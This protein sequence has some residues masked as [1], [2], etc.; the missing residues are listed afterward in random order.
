MLPFGG[1]DTELLISSDASVDL[2]QFKVCIFDG[3][4]PWLQ[5]LLIMLTIL[6]KYFSSYSQCLLKVY[7]GH[8]TVA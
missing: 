4:K 6:D 7:A 1:T 2:E 3:T 5:Y 8:K